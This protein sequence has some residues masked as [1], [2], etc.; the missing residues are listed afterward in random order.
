V[1]ISDFHKWFH[2]GRITCKWFHKSKLMEKFWFSHVISLKRVTGTWQAIRKM[3]IRNKSNPVGLPKILIWIFTCE[4]T[5]I[6]YNF[7][8]GVSLVIH[9]CKRTCPTEF[10]RWFTSETFFFG[11]EGYTPCE[12]QNFSN[13]FSLMKI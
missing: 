13:E 6:P 5:D 3:S 2:L 7:L 12:S 10:T 11:T 4:N 1:K 8:Y 9:S